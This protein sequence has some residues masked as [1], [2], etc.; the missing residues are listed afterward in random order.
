[1]SSNPKL[2]YETDF[3]EWSDRTAAL[4]RAGKFSEVDVEN[5]AEEIE[6]LGKSEHQLRHRIVQVLE[7]LLKLRLTS[8]PH[9]G[10]QRARLAGIDLSPTG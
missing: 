5:V 9:A 4:I 7:D 6:S 3:A 10:K 8:G 2:L 1:M